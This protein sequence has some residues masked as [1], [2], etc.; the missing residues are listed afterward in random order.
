MP[1]Y[2]LLDAQQRHAEHPETFDVP[3]PAEIA[4]MRP[5]DHVKIGAT[6]T[7][8][9]GIDTERY[10]LLLNATTDG[11]RFTGVVD[12]DLVYTA[13]HGLRYGDQLTVLSRHL[14]DTLKRGAA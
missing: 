12:N 11:E 3:T 7:P 6:F 8:T 2:T 14:M 13:H 5:G 1:N 4:A 9:E 10:W